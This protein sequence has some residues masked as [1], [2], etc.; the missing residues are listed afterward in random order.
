[1]QHYS[2]LAKSNVVY[3]MFRLQRKASL[4]NKTI[5]VKNDFNEFIGLFTCIPYSQIC[6]QSTRCMT[7]SYFKNSKIFLLTFVFLY[8][9]ASSTASYKRF[10]PRPERWHKTFGTVGS[11]VWR[12]T[13]KLINLQKFLIVRPVR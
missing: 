6:A 1:M 13:G 12:K 8:S 10:D 4:N 2:I 7:V 11:T 9:A 5:L 3:K